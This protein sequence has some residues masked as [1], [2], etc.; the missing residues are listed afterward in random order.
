MTVLNDGIR[1]IKNNKQ[2]NIKKKNTHVRVTSYKE[3]SGV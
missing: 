3:N 1:M 2:I